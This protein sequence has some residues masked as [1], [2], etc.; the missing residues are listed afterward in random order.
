[1][2]RR[3]KLSGRANRK[4]FRNSVRR[5]DRRN[6]TRRVPRGGYHL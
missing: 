1:M 3:R 5:T 6:V 4:L 2:R